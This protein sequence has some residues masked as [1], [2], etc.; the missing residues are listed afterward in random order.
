MHPLSQGSSTFYVKKGFASR[1]TDKT[2]KRSRNVKLTDIG[3]ETVE[4]M[5]PLVAELRIRGWQGLSD[6]DFEE[7][8]RMIDQVFENYK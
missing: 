8:V 1:E 7:F 6:E 2:D 4:K 3:R 5:Q